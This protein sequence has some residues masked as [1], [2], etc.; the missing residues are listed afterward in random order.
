VL[1]ALAGLA[2][3]DRGWGRA[4]ETWNAL[5]TV[6]SLGG[7]DWFKLGDRDLGLHLLRTQALR[8]GEPLSS[9]TAR[10]TRA[11]GVDTTLLPATDDYAAHVYRD[12]G[13]DVLLPGM[14]RR[15]RYIATRSTQSTCEAT[16]V[17][18]RACSRHCR[19]PT[20]C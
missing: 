4:S 6:S 8:A 11:A 16:L 20:C 13:W 18:R 15:A 7:E 3:E 10:I 12:G 9:F 14:V 5:D 17:R 19:P 2:D 1:Y